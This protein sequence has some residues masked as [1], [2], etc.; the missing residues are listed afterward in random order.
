VTD[1][2]VVVPNWNGARVLGACLAALARQEEIAAE[3]LVVDNGSTDGSDLLAE[4]NGVR[5]LRLGRNTGFGAAANRGVAETRAPLVA[6]LNSDACP[7]PG[8]L[9]RLAAVATTSSPDVWAWGS[10]QLRPDGAVES[11]GDAWSL[12]GA[13]YKL[14]S[15]EP[16]TVLPEQPFEVFSPPGAA[17][18]FRRAAFEE[19]GGY[20]A[21]FFLYYEDIELAWRARWRGWRS[22]TV[23]T[24]R[25]RHELGGSGDAA[26]TQRFA[27]RNSLITTVRHVPRLRP[28]VLLRHTVHEAVV[29]QQRGVLKPYLQG[30]AAGV[31]ALPSALGDRRRSRRDHTVQESELVRFLQGQARAIPLA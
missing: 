14:L 16:V 12:G 13:A 2:A 27:A 1:V 3:V 9:R 18:L 15:G 24:A 30:R 8:W 31:A 26:R 20:D 6:V 4:E 11:A 22:L 29:A 19:L 28:W 21:S 25:V 17:P 23:P 7:E 5:V 10:V